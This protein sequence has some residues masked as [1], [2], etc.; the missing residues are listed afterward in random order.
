MPKRHDLEFVKQ[1][2]ESQNCELLENEYKNN[3]TLM[4]YKCSCGEQGCIRF[5]DFQQ[6][7]R[8]E[9]CGYKKL[10]KYSS[11]V[12]GSQQQELITGSLL[13]DGSLTK[14][15]SPN[16]N[17]AFVETHGI[18]QK[19]YLLWKQ[20]LLK[21]LSYKKLMYQMRPAILPKKNGKLCRDKNRMLRCCLLKTSSHWYFTDL[22]KKWYL[23]NID[24]G[25][26]F[27]SAGNRIKTVPD[28]VMTPFVLSV[29]Y[30]DDGYNRPKQKTAC[31]CSQNFSE[32]ECLILRDK[33]RSL[34]IKNEVTKQKKIY[35]GTSTYFDF[36]EIIKMYLPCNKIAYKVDWE[37]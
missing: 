33:I 25:Y 12:L 9:K 14:V 18:A 22:E 3:R 17:S 27:D 34:G 30:F 35:I 32:Q 6:G 28:I 13:G 4:C 36:M 7:V 16:Q 26:V 19:S 24:G 8:C 20:E 10:M 5:D 21:P 31:I 29:W 11:V 1:Q 15:Y 37:H 2:F 23:R